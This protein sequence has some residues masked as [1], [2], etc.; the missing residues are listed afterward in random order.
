[1]VNP[2]DAAFCQECG[3]KMYG[4]NDSEPTS[5]V[6]YSHPHSKMKN[7]DSETRDVIPIDLADAVRICLSEKFVSFSGRAKRAEYWYFQLFQL[8]ISGFLWFA[9][10]LYGVLLYEGNLMAILEDIKIIETIFILIMFLPNLSVTIRRLHDLDMHG[11]WILVNLVPFLGLLL[12]TIFCLMKS[13][14]HDNKYGKLV[15]NDNAVRTC[16]SKMFMAFSGRAKRAEYWYFQ[17]FLLIISGFLLFA[18]FVYGV[19]IYKGNLEAVLHDIEITEAIF[20]LIMFLPNLSVTIRRLHDIG[21]H[22]I[23][24]FV[25]LVPFLGSLIITIFCLMGSQMHDN[26]YGKLVF[27]DK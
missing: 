2:D 3:A 21:F 6:V 16:L 22:G 1:M 12:T 24:V 15:L 8:I 20:F 26:K 27:N 13:Q 17:Q 25:N 23:V 14:M 9:T 11:A 18:S 7:E 4:E 19:L 5:S 10:F